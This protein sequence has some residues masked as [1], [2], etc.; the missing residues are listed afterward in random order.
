[1]GMSRMAGDRAR[2]AFS[3]DAET[4]TRRDGTG[5]FLV[6]LAVVVAAFEWWNIPGVF[7]NAV[8][9]VFEGPLGE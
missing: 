8:R 7:G 9:G 1:M 6:G 3:E 2:K 5:F 4:P